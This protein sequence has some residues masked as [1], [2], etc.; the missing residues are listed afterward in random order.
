MNL[1]LMCAGSCSDEEFF[2]SLGCE[3]QYEEQSE[4]AW[5]EAAHDG[6]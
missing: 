3:K 6:D 4:K 1:C 2:C 5:E